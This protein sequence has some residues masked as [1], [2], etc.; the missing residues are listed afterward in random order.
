[1]TNTEIADKANAINKKITD[2]VAELYNFYDE[3][4]GESKIPTASKQMIGHAYK[5]VLTGSFIVRDF[6]IEMRASE[7]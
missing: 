5:I 1:M 4:N 6:E 2:A 3:L 7:A